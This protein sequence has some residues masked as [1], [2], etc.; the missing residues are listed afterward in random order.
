MSLVIISLQCMGLQLRKGV[1]AAGGLL[2]YNH[3]PE[4]KKQKKL[5]L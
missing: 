5:N 3:L 4:G 2:L 1:G